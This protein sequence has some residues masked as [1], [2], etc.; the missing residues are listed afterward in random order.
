MYFVFC[1]FQSLQSLV[2]VLRILCCSLYVVKMNKEARLRLWALTERRRKAKE[3]WE[4]AGCPEGVRRWWEEP[5]WVEVRANNGQRW[6][7]CVD[8]QKNCAGLAAACQAAYDWV[9]ERRA[10]Q[11]QQ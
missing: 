6:A 11:G 9:K 8:I 1:S 5:V 3:E 4:R 2:F 10:G 7:R